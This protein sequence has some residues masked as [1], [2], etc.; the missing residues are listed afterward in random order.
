MTGNVI[1]NTDPAIRAVVH[2]QDLLKQLEG[3]YLPEGLSRDVSDFGDGTL[4]QIPT[5]GQMPLY[6]IAEGEDTPLSSLDTGTVTL[7]IQEHK[8]TGGAIS[9]ELKEDGYKALAVEAEIVPQSLRSIKEAYETDFL[10]TCN[11]V[12]T[13]ASANVINGV[14]HRILASGT[15]NVITLDDIAYLKL[16]FDEADVPDEGRIL[17][18]PSIAE[19]TFNTLVGAQAFTNNP[20]FEGMVGEGFAKNRKFIRN[21]F[22][23]DIWTSTRLPTQAAA[24]S[25]TATNILPPV[26]ATNNRS[27]GQKIGVAMCVADD[28]TKPIMGAWRRAPRVEGTR[29]TS[30]RRDEFHVTARWG[31]GAQRLEPLATIAVSGTSY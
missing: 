18:L 1:L 7:T 20:M 9:D 10:S 19:L 28:M 3:D 26:G 31:F 13:S 5:V 25:I 29:N 4:L 24:E 6:D 12:Q 14:S 23:F 22:G 17:L 11:S 21:M 15:N 8:G 30:K 2:S 27:A 16:A